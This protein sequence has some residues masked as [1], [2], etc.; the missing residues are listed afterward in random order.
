MSVSQGRVWGA[1]KT[2]S[3]SM[4]RNPDGLY[5]ILAG[6]DVKTIE[7]GMRMPA[8]CYCIREKGGIWV[9]VAYWSH[10]IDMTDPRHFF[11]GLYVGVRH[12]LSRSRW[13]LREKKVFREGISMLQVATGGTVEK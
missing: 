3:R 9:A 4:L 13:S 8:D 1:G 2:S 10:D 5:M 7:R 12:A 11:K 6:I